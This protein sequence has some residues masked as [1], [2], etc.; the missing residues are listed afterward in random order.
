MFFR[1]AKINLRMK[2]NFASMTTFLILNYFRNSKSL[3][4][5][6]VFSKKKRLDFFSF[7]LKRKQDRFQ[8]SRTPTLFLKP[9][10]QS[11]ANHGFCNRFSSG[12]S[13][14]RKS[15]LFTND[16]NSPSFFGQKQKSLTHHFYQN[17]WRFSRNQKFSCICQF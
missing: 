12:E 3:I 1:S 5:E 2:I 13:E 16:N 4:Y 9:L 14:L 6:R 8:I 17:R 7:L 11:L 15:K 10:K